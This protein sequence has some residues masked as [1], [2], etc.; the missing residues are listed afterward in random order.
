MAPFNG[1]VSGFS[2]AINSYYF[3]GLMLLPV[4]FVLLISG[5]LRVNIYV[6]RILAI[7]FLLVVWG[8]VSSFLNPLLF[9]NILVFSPRLGID[10]QVKYGPTALVWSFS[11]FG[12]AIYLLINFNIVLILLMK[13]RTKNEFKNVFLKSFKV[14]IPIMIVFVVWQICSKMYGI[15]FPSEIIYS[16]NDRGFAD[17]TMNGLFRISGT[18]IEPSVLGGVL[19]SL[20]ICSMWLKTYSNSFL[21]KIYPIIIILSAFATLSTTGYVATLLVICASFIQIVIRALFYLKVRGF[22]LIYFVILV[23]V[24]FYLYFQFGEFLQNLIG[25]ILFDKLESIS[26]V[27]RS[28]ANNHAFDVFKDTYG[29]GAGLGSNRPSSFLFAILS[30]LG[31]IGVILTSALLFEIINAY[32]KLRKVDRNLDYTFLMFISF[33]SSMVIAIPDLSNEFLWICLANFLVNANVLINRTGRKYLDM[34]TNPAL[35]K[36]VYHRNNVY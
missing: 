14:A 13:V 21:F 12:Q 9:E 32:S 1:D 26:M 19:A 15:Y 7:L 36:N 25:V 16:V 29:M 11:N 24:L 10:T 6:K 5:Q 3:L 31:I 30:N 28:A 4:S 23:I 18:M 27:S 35:Q 20:L 2:F 17:Q 8:I 34:T 22:A 33:L